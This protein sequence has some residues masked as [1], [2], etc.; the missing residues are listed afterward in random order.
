MVD[1]DEVEKLR[2]EQQEKN[3]VRRKLLKEKVQ[4]TSKAPANASNASSD[5]KTVPIQGATNGSASSTAASSGS[6]MVSDV[7]R[8]IGNA[9]KLTAQGRAEIELFLRNDGGPRGKDAPNER[10][11][12]LTEKREYIQNRTVIAVERVFLKLTHDPRRWAKVRKRQCFKN[13]NL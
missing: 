12:L 4:Q 9:P 6:G 10:S 8:L 13:P 7:M 5:K 3:A 1:Y 2:A 11:F